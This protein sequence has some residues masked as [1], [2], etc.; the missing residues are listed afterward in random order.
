MFQLSY[1][2]IDKSVVFTKI[3][4][5]KE[6]EVT[7]SNLGASVFEIS[8]SDN[9]NNMENILMAPPKDIWLNNLSLIHI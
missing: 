2:H 6:L 4:L 5:K 7:F 3:S 9:R 1:D 8:F